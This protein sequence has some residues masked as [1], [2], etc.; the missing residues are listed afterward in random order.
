M[1]LLWALIIVF[2][3]IAIFGGIFIAKLLWFILIVALILVLVS[4]L[5]RGRI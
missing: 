3:L 1:S 4:F 2:V 5:T